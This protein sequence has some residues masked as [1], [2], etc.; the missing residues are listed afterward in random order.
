MN[1]INF[2]D[3]MKKY[4]LK[5]DTMN[6]SLLQKISEAP[7]YPRDSRIDSDKE[8][9]NIDDATQGGTPWCWF[10]IKDNK[11]SYFESFGGLVN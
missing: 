2:K 6:E 10:I 5:N 7:I 11:S 1:T 9:G 8:F 3:F 4:N